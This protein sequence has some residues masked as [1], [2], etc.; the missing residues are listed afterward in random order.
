LDEVDY[1]EEVLDGEIWGR[2]GGNGVYL[3]PS[4]SGLR[5]MIT[6]CPTWVVLP[7]R[8]TGRGEDMM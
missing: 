8:M 4:Y 1:W 3:V 5:A 6:P 7:H 2:R